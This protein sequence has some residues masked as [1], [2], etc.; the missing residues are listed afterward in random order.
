MRAPLRNRTVDLLLTMATPPR[1]DCASC[2]ESTAERTQY[3]ECMHCPLHPVHDP[4]HDPEAARARQ[5][6]LSEPAAVT[7]R[8]QT[9]PPSA[10]LA[11]MSYLRQGHRLIS[12]Y[13]LPCTESPI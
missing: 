6:T 8:A 7:D 11:W 1:P 13:Y 2:T 5:I 9:R 3:T 10:R 4:V 12:L